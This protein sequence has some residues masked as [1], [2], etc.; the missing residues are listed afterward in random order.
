[1]KIALTAIVL[2]RARS[3]SEAMD[4]L[5]ADYIDRAARYMPCSSQLFDSEPLFLE[6]LAHKPG[7]APAYGVLLDSRGK[8]FASE[9]FAAQI[10]RLRDSGTQNL[11]FAIGPAD[12]WSATAR[13]R[14]NLLLS[15]GLMTLPHQLARVVLAE[16]VYRALT[17]LAGHPYHSGH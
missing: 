16:Q 1:M 9:D 8:Q 10:G 13:S 7:R 3:K 14:A 2:R 11:V 15:F 17:I 12:G 5:L 4:R 6:W